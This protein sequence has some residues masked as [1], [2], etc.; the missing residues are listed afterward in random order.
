[1]KHSLTTFLLALFLG[2]SSCTA[3]SDKAPAGKSDKNVTE[4]VIGNIMARRSIRKFTA[5]TVSRDTLDRIIECGI[6]APNGMNAQNYE[7]R[8]VDDPKS[9]A[10]LSENLRGLYKAPVYLFIAANE[11]YDMAQIDCGLLSEN[12][13]LSA[14]A[15][16]LG[17][18]NLGM[19]VR[20]IKERRDLL[21]KLGFSEHYN[22]CLIVALGF[23]DE[24]PK[25]KPRNR[26]K[27]R[28]IKVVGE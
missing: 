9:V 13:C 2:T 14:T 12:I 27:V 21:E 26:D 28:F 7:V 23:P 15:Y 5:Q 4:T 6:N 17:T 1:M 8:V 22:L 16:G 11:E 24:A 20:S 19:P 10:Y 25:A 18:I 3:S